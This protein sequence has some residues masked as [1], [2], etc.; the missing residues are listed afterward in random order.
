MNRD[1]LDDLA[2]LALGSRL[3]RM[4]ERMLAD[5]AQIYQH[6]GIDIQPKWFTLLA[7]LDH[8]EQVSV[9]EAAE[10]LG[11]SQPALSQFCRQLAQKKL[12]TFTV[13]KQDSRK[14]VV[15]L[16]ALG[17]QQVELMRPMWQAV[18]RAAEELCAESGYDFYPALQ[19]LEQAHSRRSLLQR[20][21]DYLEQAKPEVQNQESELEFVPFDESLAPHF[22]TIN[23]EWIENMFHLEDID[24]H[25][26][27][28]PQDKILSKGGQI[29]FAR[30]AT[31]GVVGTCAL[32]NHGNG[33]FELTKMG[34][35]D[36]ARGL[37]IGE[38]LLRFV[39]EQAQGMDI[40]RLFL[41]TNAKCE[42]AIHLYEKNGFH[43]DTTIM[44]EFGAAYE[45]CNVAMLY[46][47]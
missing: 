32:L 37:K 28:H 40:Q 26:L 36:A 23:R 38:Q 24:L 11:L 3:K 6:F 25:V 45:R 22:E 1:F 33:D 5:A 16:S 20:T 7:L 27:Q 35:L 42:A 18:K 43:H 21:Q 46:R 44:Q 47:N 12:V 4:S 15:A 13:D 29:W 14:R 9:V 39:I 30:H 17:K 19:Q 10:S 31:L 34:V 8:K 2:E 41:L